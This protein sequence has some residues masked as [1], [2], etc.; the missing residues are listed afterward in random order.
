VFTLIAETM[1]GEL[2]RGENWHELLL[3]QMMKNIP[4]IRPAVI[5]PETGRLLDELRRFRHVGFCCFFR[6]RIILTIPGPGGS[7][8]GEGDGANWGR[9]IVHRKMQAKGDYSNE[10]DS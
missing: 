6:T 5:S 10:R 7:A 2:P 3:R 9:I 4:G 1:E 8:P